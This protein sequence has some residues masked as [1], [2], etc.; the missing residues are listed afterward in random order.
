M[1]EASAGLDYRADIAID[2]L[3]LHFE[4]GMQNCIKFKSS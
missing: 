4:D 1:I 3:S 2:D